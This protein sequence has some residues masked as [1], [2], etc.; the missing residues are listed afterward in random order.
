[1]NPQLARYAVAT[2]ILVSYLLGDTV[3]TALTH[4]G[5]LTQQDAANKA[6]KMIH[7]MIAEARAQGD[8]EGDA[9]DRPAA[10]GDCSSFWQWPGSRE[11][12]KGMARQVL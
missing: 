5:H 4:Y 8:R 1:M 10:A 7:M 12:P 6:G 11:R 3:Q 9:G 2:G